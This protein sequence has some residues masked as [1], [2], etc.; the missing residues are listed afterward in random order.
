MDLDAKADGGNAQRPLMR[1]A[2]RAWGER[3]GSSRQALGNFPDK[4]DW[5]GEDKG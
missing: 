5:Y 1:G 4:G 2:W 3:V